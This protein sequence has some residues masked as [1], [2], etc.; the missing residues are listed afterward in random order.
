VRDVRAAIFELHTS[1]APG[2]SV[3]QELIELCAESA[4]NLG[5]EPVI[6]FNGPIDTAVQESAADELFAVTREALTNVAKH[7]GART[8]EVNVEVREGC[9][10]VRVTDDGIGFDRNNGIGRGVGNLEARASRLGGTF[11]ITRVE[12]AGTDLCWSVPLG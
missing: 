12:P 6:R 1:R 7:A 9:L 2:R 3:R 11:E 4:R 8:V 10:T 5:F